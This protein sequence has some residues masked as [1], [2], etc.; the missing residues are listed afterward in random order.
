MVEGPALSCPSHRDHSN[1]GDV[2]DRLAEDP[3]LR[4][5][6][7]WAEV[8]VFNEHRLSWL[9]APASHMVRICQGKENLKNEIN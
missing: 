7:S 9:A 6:P 8:L 2:R 3:G 5:H 4:F 1:G